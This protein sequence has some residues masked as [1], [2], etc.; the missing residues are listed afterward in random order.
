MPNRPR[1][2][3]AVAITLSACA[4]AACSGNAAGR[5]GVDAPSTP[6]PTAAVAAPNAPPR[7]LAV[8]FS[9]LRVA[10]GQSWS[11]KIATGTNVASVEVRTESFTID[12]PR[13]SF[14]QFAFHLRVLDVPPFLQRSYTLRVIARNAAG[15]AE[16]EDFPFS[17]RGLSGPSSKRLSR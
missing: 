17:F 14:G 5:P 12:V 9:R 6:W 3:L 15:Q 11:G 8:H 13:T 4:T 10:P 2:R 7:I 16:E 1:A